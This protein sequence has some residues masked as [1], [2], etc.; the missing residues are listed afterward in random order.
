MKIVVAPDSFKGSLSAEEVG[1]TIKA[2][3]LAAVPD[4]QVAVIP[5]ADGGEGTLDTLLFAADGRKIE[6]VA[7]GPLGEQM[8]ACYGILGDGETAVIEMAQVAGLPLLSAEERNPMRTTT[9]GVGELIVAAL[10]QGLRSFIIG[11]G[12]SATNDGGMG[13]LQ[14]LGAVFLDQSGQQVRPI[15]GALQE[16]VAV[17]FSGL[18]PKIRDCRFR[19]ASDVENPLCGLNGASHVFGPQKGAT[20]AQVLQLD[21]ALG[22]YAAL[23]E[24]ALQVKLQHQPGAGAAGGLGFGFLVLGAE[25]V[26]GSQLVAEATGL[27]EEIKTADW[28]I[29]GEGQSDAQTLMGK[30]PFFVANTAK[31]HVVGTILISGGLGQGHEAL[32]EHFT[33][34]FSVANA[35]MT[36]GKAI[37][38]AKPLLFSCARNIARLLYKASQHK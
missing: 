33:A 15:G 34:C 4:V 22:H 28:V 23:I 18:H 32:L 10:E 35:P 12:G 8:P 25:I 29:T 14:A 16:I 20:E 3:F 31:K 5:M 17:D 36:L 1:V 6:A 27:E 21:K 30:V 19:I 2:A 26:S 11:L 37:A 9:F 24:Q 7:T 13:M 38:Q